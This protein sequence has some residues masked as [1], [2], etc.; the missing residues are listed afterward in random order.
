M[1]NGYFLVPLM[2]LHF[3]QLFSLPGALVSLFSH[4]PGFFLRSSL[5]SLKISD[6]SVSNMK[7]YLT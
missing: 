1:S 3:A 6:L 4:V 7:F 2:N 5:F